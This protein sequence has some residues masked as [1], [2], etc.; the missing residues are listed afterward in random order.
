MGLNKMAFSPEEVKEGLHKTLLDYL[1]DYNAKSNDW[2]NDIHVTTDGY[3][4]IVCW[5]QVPVKRDCGG[6]F[7]YIDEKDMDYVPRPALMEWPL[8][9]EAIASIGLSPDFAEEI[10]Q[11][12]K[13]EMES[14]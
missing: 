8:D 5:D 10:E 7:V 1:L 4:T 13:K 2:M 14:K 11:E 12:I 3:C 6:G 9:L